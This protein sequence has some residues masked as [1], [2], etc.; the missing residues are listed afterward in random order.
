MA[1]DCYPKIPSGC[2]QTIYQ[3]SPVGISLI[4]HL[5]WLVVPLTY[6]CYLLLVIALLCELHCRGRNGFTDEIEVHAVCQ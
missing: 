1:S 5:P 2:F 6:Q 4:L 3:V